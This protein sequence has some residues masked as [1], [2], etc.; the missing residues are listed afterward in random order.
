MDS[1]LK[2]E[3][4]N[5]ATIPTGELGP[6]FERHVGAV[7]I[8]SVLY[9]LILGILFWDGF[10]NRSLYFVNLFAT[11]AYLY[12]IYFSIKGD[13]F[14]EGKLITLVVAFNLFFVAAYNYL[15]FLD[16][17]DL[18]AF[19][20]AD[21]ET[22]H[23]IADY[24]AKGP[25]KDTLSYFPWYLPNDDKGFVVYASLVYRIIPSNLMLNFFNIILNV[26][27]T[28]LI[29]KLGKF[30]LSDKGAFL[31][32]IIYGLATYTIFYEASGLKET[33]MVFLTVA[34]FYFFVACME[35]PRFI[36]FFLALFFCFLLGF[37]R[38]PIIFFVLLAAATVYFCKKT[39]NR[40]L[41]DPIILI[42]SVG[43][44]FLFVVVFY[45]YLARYFHIFS[46]VMFRKEAIVPYEGRFIILVSAMSA[47]FGPFSTI[48]PMPGK[49]NLSIIAGSLILKT[50]L[51]A[52][53]I[54]G[55]YFA[56]K[57]KNAIALGLACFCLAEIFGL[58]YLLESFEFR[59][60]FP[61]IAF[62]LLL[63][64][65]GFENLQKSESEFKLLRKGI[66]ATNLGLVVVIFAWNILRN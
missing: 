55:I 64:V 66:F 13:S 20:A 7:W 41:S 65:Y 3:I 1:N 17:G 5:S 22:Y 56:L 6:E 19:T 50:L 36:S 9:F 2:S 23:Y 53:F 8:I 34:S 60:N 51:S 61:H 44:G 59:L 31:A 58:L 4:T 43:L 33:L 40:T 37:F 45:E 21:S 27:T 54:V 16:R 29:Y 12:I 28:V 24:I 57:N 15:F 46:D 38:V 18:L 49:E 26:A 62:L 39:K 35:K 42:I 32:A 52:H 47:F 25:I 63:G 14:N 48:V 11:T 10:T 30:I